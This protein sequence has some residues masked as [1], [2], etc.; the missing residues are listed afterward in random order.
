MSFLFFFGHALKG[1]WV[2]LNEERNLK[3]H[4]VA[5]VIVIALGFYFAISLLEWIVI[6]LLMGLVVGFE[7]INTAIEN[8]T[9][10]VTE[11]KHPLAGKVKDISTAAVLF[12]ALISV[13]VGMIIF[14][15]YIF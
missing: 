12:I 13:I 3:I 2:A 15:R 9:N 7:L 10:L 11:E 1:F 5:S 14:A 6:L 4:L 8:L